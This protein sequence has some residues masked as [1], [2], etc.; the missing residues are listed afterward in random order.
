MA[1]YSLLVGYI[2]AWIPWNLGVYSVFFFLSMP[3]IFYFVITDGKQ[4]RGRPEYSLGIGII[5]VLLGG[6]YI[7]SDDYFLMQSSYSFSRA[8]Y[9]I[10][11]SCYQERE[12]Y[13]YIKD[14]LIHHEGNAV[15]VIYGPRGIGKSTFLKQ[16]AKNNPGVFYYEITDD[17][18]EEPFKNFLRKLFI[19][20]AYHPV[21]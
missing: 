3:I 10:T 8:S 19:S 16:F 1:V 9:N 11:D 4:I 13:S 5:A 2:C 14:Q 7:L 20:P 18:F 12:I 6:F 21:T 17:D 15:G